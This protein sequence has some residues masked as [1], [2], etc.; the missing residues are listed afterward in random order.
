MS[1]LKL[2]SFAAVSATALLCAQAALAADTAADAVE[3]DKVTVTATRSETRLQDAP[4][5]A[6]VISD[7]DIEDGLVKDIK[8]LVRFEPGVSVRSAPARF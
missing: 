6:S 3:L 4:V 2:A 5:T 1:R 8:D 7:Q